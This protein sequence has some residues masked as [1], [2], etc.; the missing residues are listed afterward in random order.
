MSRR[1]SGY[2]VSHPVRDLLL[3]RET[4]VDEDFQWFLHLLADSGEDLSADGFGISC[5]WRDANCECC[6]ERKYNKSVND[7]R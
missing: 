3:N 4:T 2:F 6:C 7:V 1:N 5:K